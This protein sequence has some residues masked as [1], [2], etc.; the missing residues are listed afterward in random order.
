MKSLRK[1]NQEICGPISGILIVNTFTTKSLRF[2]PVILSCPSH[3][4]VD[5]TNILRAAFA[6][7][8]SKAQIDSQV[9]SVFLCF[10][11]LCALK[12]HVNMLVKLNPG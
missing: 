1:S 3:S 7:V 5:F 8:D 2:E 10:R 9:I 4:W 11:G 12:L 6:R